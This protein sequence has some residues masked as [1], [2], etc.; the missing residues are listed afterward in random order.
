MFVDGILISNP[1][2]VTIENGLE[3]LVYLEVKQIL[4]TPRDDPSIADP[5]LEG[6]LTSNR[7]K[8]VWELK[9]DSEFNIAD[10]SDVAIDTWKNTMDSES[11]TKLSCWFSKD[12]RIPENRLYRVE[13]HKVVNNSVWIKWSRYNASREFSVEYKKGNKYVVTTKMPYT[14]ELKTGVIVELVNCD[15]SNVSNSGELFEITSVEY[16]PQLAVTLKSIE[17]LESD[18]DT[19][20]PVNGKMIVWFEGLS[21]DKVSSIPVKVGNG[22][23]VIDGDIN[24]SISDWSKASPGDYWHITARVGHFVPNEKNDVKTKDSYPKKHYCPI[25][26]VV[27]DNVVDVRKSFT[28]LAKRSDFR[29][30][31]IEYSVSNLRRMNLYNDSFIPIQKNNDGVWI[32]PSHRIAKQSIPMN[33]VNTFKIYITTTKPIDI[34]SV[35]TTRNNISYIKPSILLT[36]VIEEEHTSTEIIHQIKAN[37]DDSED[38]CTLVINASHIFDELNNR[39]DSNSNNH[40]KIFLMQLKINGNHILDESGNHLDCDSFSSLDG[41][42]NKMTYPTGDGAPGGLFAMWFW[43]EFSDNGVSFDAINVYPESNK[44]NSISELE[45]GGKYSVVVTLDGNVSEDVQIT[46]GHNSKNASFFNMNGIDGDITKTIPEGSNSCSIDLYIG[47]RTQFADEIFT[48]TASSD[49]VD[50]Q[51]ETKLTIVAPESPILDKVTLDIPSASNGI[52]DTNKPYEMIISAFDQYGNPFTPDATADIELSSK[53][54]DTSIEKVLFGSSENSINSGTLKCTFDR[55]VNTTTC[56]FKVNQSTLVS[57]EF[58]ITLSVDGVDKVTKKLL[59]IHHIPS[60][61]EIE[62]VGRP[63]IRVGESNRKFVLCLKNEDGSDFVP[64]EDIKCDIEVQE[65]SDL[66]ISGKKKLIPI[67]GESQSFIEKPLKIS[68]DIF[69]EHGEK[70][71]IKFTIADKTFE[72][73]IQVC[74]KF[75]INGEIR[76]K[77]GSNKIEDE[78]GNVIELDGEL[79]HRNGRTLVPVRSFVERILGGTVSYEED[80]KKI[81]CTVDDKPLE[82]FI[83][84]KIALI[85]GMTYTLDE[86][87]SI[88]NDIAYVQFRP[89]CEVFGAEI[90]YNSST[91][92]IIFNRGRAIG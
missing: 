21:A 78:K 14:E 8:Y 15:D 72:K 39:C 11:G 64:S 26:V 52:V 32:V 4:T 27:G 51:G 85:D 82:M 83:L 34:N 45:P 31:Q 90:E 42:R 49:Q 73:Q 63:C 92:E 89:L 47:S 66:K 13:V 22:D 23:T 2:S 88:I 69:N 57:G 33:K 30:S 58:E 41:T 29:I 17:P 74:P 10:T 16:E 86:P 5:A 70:V 1:E 76:M 28:P 12:C 35:V 61:V 19:S 20:M 68:N 24:I 3:G 7:F 53:N 46:I 55:N 54:A 25:A 36:S 59:I 71:N 67:F 75:N 48:I 62:L 91:R 40:Q 38:S 44:S 56:Y 84:K 18:K 6:M 37:V 9:C 77:L 50:N 65:S 80:T 43:I 81:T 87:P 79:V 60:D